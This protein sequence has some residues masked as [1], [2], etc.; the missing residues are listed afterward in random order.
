MSLT[1]TLTTNLVTETTVFNVEIESEGSSCSSDSLSLAY[2]VNPLEEII[3]SEGNSLNQATCYGSAITPINFSGASR[4]EVSWSPSQP[5]GISP[6]N[7]ALVSPTLQISGTHSNTSVATTSYTYTLSLID[8]GTNCIT[9][10]T[11]TGTLTFYPREDLSISSGTDSQTLCTGGE[12]TPIIYDLSSGYN[13]STYEVGWSSLPTQ[14][15]LN[16]SYDEA[17]SSLT[18]SGSVPSSVTT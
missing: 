3:L 5:V 17:E 7:G 6:P 1:G 8:V 9:S 18:L 16:F 13:N 4:Y 11:V 15:G 10:D 14:E 2:Y 12:I